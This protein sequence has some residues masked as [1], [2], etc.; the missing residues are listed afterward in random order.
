MAEIKRTL[1]KT[2]NPF[3]D[4]VSFRLKTSIMKW[5]ILL[6]MLMFSGTLKAA[7]TII[8]NKDSRLDSLAQKQAEINKRTSMMT[9]SGQYKGYRIQVLNTSDRELAFRVKADLL[10]NYPDQ[11]SHIIFR[12]PYFKVRIGDFLKRSDAESFRK[13]L[14]GTYPQGGYIVA[15]LI[16]YNPE[17]D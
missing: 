5:Y 13:Q 17:E 9:S 10:A 7:D 2:S 4:Y 15:D 6:S 12:S 11:K 3:P 16:D 14:T 8:V 1:L